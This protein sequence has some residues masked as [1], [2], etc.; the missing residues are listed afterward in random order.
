MVNLGRKLA[1]GLYGKLEFDFSCNRGHA[2][3]EHYLHGVL[4]EILASHI[5]PNETS[6]EPSFA[7]PALQKPNS[8]G[9][10]RELDFA[11]VDREDNSS[12]VHIE[13]KWAGSSH[14]KPNTILNDL[15]RLVVMKNSNPG[16]TNLFVLAGGKDRVDHLLNSGLLAPQGAK[17]QRLLAYPFD[18]RVRTFNFDRNLRPTV[19]AE[20]SSRLPFLPSGVHST[21]YKPSHDNVP[22]WRVLVWRVQ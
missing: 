3:G 14:C 2:F 11:L 19:K 5:A 18:S 21:L 6:L 22:N 7:A 12:F 9:R 13:A 1:D 17:R 15:G 20:L 16:S 10:K 8:P 4:N